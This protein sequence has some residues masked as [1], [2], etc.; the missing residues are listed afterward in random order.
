MVS[1]DDFRWSALA[2]Y[3]DAALEHA[4]VLTALARMK[5][6]SH[7]DYAS[8]L[9]IRPVVRLMT[10]MH[11]FCFSTR[12]AI[13]ISEAKR[14]GVKALALQTKLYGGGREVEIGP[15]QS[16]CLS[17]RDFWWII[18][19]IIHSQQT[20]VETENVITKATQHRIYSEDHMKYFGFRSDFDGRTGNDSIESLHYVSTE[21]LVAAYV[22][23]IEPM[24]QETIRNSSNG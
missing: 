21:A 15:G 2:R 13:E 14:S 9:S 11:G 22:M 8:A 12:K 23:E 5:I 3:N 7:F 6:Q 19:R 17:N 20:H 1:L 4:V 24:I 16:R 18:S 10:E